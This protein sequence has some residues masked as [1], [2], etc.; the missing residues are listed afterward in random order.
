V[1]KTTLYR[2]EENIK[3]IMCK[4]SEFEFSIVSFNVSFNFQYVII[5]KKILSHSAGTGTT[6]TKIPK[7]RLRPRVQ[8]AKYCY[9]NIKIIIIT[10]F[11]FLLLFT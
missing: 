6:M 10:I 1:Q 5:L 8:I 11:N 4:G 9:N 3:K 7:V 2:T